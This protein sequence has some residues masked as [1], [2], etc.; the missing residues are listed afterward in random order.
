MVYGTKF[1]GGSNTAG[2]LYI[3]GEP[4][5]LVNLMNIKHK[6]IKESNPDISSKCRG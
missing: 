5:V 4:W 3:S 2:K 6:A 1:A